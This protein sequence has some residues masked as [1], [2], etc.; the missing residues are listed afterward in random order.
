[1]VR[2]LRNGAVRR[3]EHILYAVIWM[4]GWVLGVWVWYV[5]DYNTTLLRYIDLLITVS[6]LVGGTLLAWHIN[7]RGDGKYFWQ[8]Y[9]SIDISLIVPTFIIVLVSQF[10][11]AL[12]R[13]FLSNGAY[14][15]RAYLDGTDVVYALLVALFVLVWSLQLMRNVSRMQ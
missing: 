12:V 1:M 9:V 4:L 6:I 11:Y 2:A 13:G 5:T 7:K 3:W 8:R 15:S 10:V 14:F